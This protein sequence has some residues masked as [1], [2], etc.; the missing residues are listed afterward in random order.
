MNHKNPQT[1]SGIPE[2]K[3]G[4]IHPHTKTGIPESVWGFFSHKPES[5]WGSFQFGTSGFFRVSSPNWNG[6]QNGTPYRNGP[7]LV[8]V[9][10]CQYSK[11]GS[12][13][14]DSRFIP[15]WGPT[16]CHFCPPLDCLKHDDAS[17]P[18]SPPCRQG[19]GEA[20]SQRRNIELR[21]KSS[22]TGGRGERHRLSRI[23]SSVHLRAYPIWNRWITWTYA[24][25]PI[26]NE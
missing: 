9:G 2:L 1:D 24:T 3:W 23:G 18:N 17:N 25:R 12:P 26:W 8:W 10:I 21:P 5:V 7:E 16:Y 4:S 11:L 22:R 14:S 20:R 13:H 19:M 15:I 6:I